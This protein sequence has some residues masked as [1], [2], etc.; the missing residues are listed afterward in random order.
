MFTSST[1]RVSKAL[2]KSTVKTISYSAI[3]L[4]LVQPCL[5]TECCR[6]AAHALSASCAG[7]A[8]PRT[9]EKALTVFLIFSVYWKLGDRM[10]ASDVPNIGG[11]LFIWVTVPAYSAAAYTPVSLSTTYITMP[12]LSKCKHWLLHLQTP[13]SCVCTGRQCAS[14]QHAAAF[15]S[16]SQDHQDD[17]CILLHVVGS[18]LVSPT[19]LGIHV[20]C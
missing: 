15:W 19:T 8:V 2:L 11:L 4:S 18:V 16:A 13:I 17:D 20:S 10:T 12:C 6:T 3:W 1:F 5:L 9:G 7:C 14:R